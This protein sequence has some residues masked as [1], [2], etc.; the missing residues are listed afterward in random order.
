MIPKTEYVAARNVGVPRTYKV[1]TTRGVAVAV[2]DYLADSA[3]DAIAMA[4][5]ELA[6]VERLMNAI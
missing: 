4:R 2:H 3:D 5:A 6:M 1:W